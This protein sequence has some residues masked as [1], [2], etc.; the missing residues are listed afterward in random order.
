MICKSVIP[1]NP[2]SLGSDTCQKLYT[3]FKLIE[4]ALIEENMGV[5]Q[6]NQNMNIIR[7]I[8][9]FCLIIFGIGL[10]ISGCQ[11]STSN[12]DGSDKDS[13]LVLRNYRLSGD[14]TWEPDRTYIVH[15]TL[16]IPA[17]VTLEILP[18]T[19][20]KF[21]RDAQIKVSGLKA[22]LKVGTPLTQTILDEL[23]YLTSNNTHPRPGDWKGILFDITRDATS[24]LRGTVIEFAQ[25]ALDIK[26]TSPTVLDCTLRNNETALALDGS[27]SII[28]YND[29]L[30]N[31]IGI[32]TIE[33][34]NRPQIQYNNINSN[35]F[36]IFCENVQSIIRH[37]NFEKNDYSI[38]LNVKFDLAIPDN[39]WGT[40]ANNEIERVIL[41]SADTDI[42][43]KPIGTVTYTPIAETRFEEAGPRE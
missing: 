8:A 27:D 37:N 7:F 6:Q 43:T 1:V 36:G 31:E 3:P 16:E 40:L 15:G 2:V 18:G 32:S 10:A 42:I 14:E 24:Y 29:I 5:L 21:D 19:V 9:F 33:R 25:I 30:E 28:Q 26:T 12:I 17:E 39:W 20:V 22:I 41:D 11:D 38:K 13:E 4:L 35:E 34:Q 23:V